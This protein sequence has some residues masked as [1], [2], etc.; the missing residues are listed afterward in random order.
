[1]KKL[2]SA[3]IILSLILANVSNIRAS[4]DTTALRGLK[5]VVVVLPPENV[6]EKWGIFP[7][8]LRTAAELPL[9][10]IGLN[11]ESDESNLSIPRIIIDISPKDGNK[12]LYRVMIR[13]NEPVTP[14]RA[15]VGVICRDT[16]NTTY[17]Y[18]LIYDSNSSERLIEFSKD[19]I[20][21]F[22]NDYLAA[23]QKSAK[24]EQ[25]TTYAN[26]YWANFAKDNPGIPGYQ[27]FKEEYDKFRAAGMDH[28]RAIDS[29]TVNFE[30]RIK[31]IK[32]GKE[33]IPQY[34]TTQPAK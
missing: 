16:Y 4:S 24:L 26:A 8:N 2:F 3:S 7:T 9:R 17:Q 18:G 31:N 1:M 13:M 6:L 21:E 11:L 29:A 32:E 33:K 28:E 14:L 30:Q 22:C 15:G 5:K 23:N 20:E 19:L 12:N 10:K 25:D 34:P 27:I